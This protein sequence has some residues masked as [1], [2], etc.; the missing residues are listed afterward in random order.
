MH[1]LSRVLVRPSP[2]AQ[3]L[4]D[5]T[6]P[7]TSDFT[8]LVGGIGKSGS[9]CREAQLAKVRK[10]YVAAQLLEVQDKLDLIA[11]RFDSFLPRDSP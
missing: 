11:K 10:P 1:I 4:G 7:F 5:R 6:H 3:L 2:L 9:R 8:I